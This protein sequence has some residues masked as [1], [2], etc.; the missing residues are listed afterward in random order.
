[1]SD[2]GSADFGPLISRNSSDEAIARALNLFVGRG[3]RY[4]VK[5]FSAATGIPERMIECAK[6]DIE[7]SDHRSLAPHLIA[8]AAKFLG[9]AFINVWL[10]QCGLA[11]CASAEPNHDDIARAS[12]DY[13]AAY[14]AARHPD[15]PGGI[16]IIASEKRQLNEKHQDLRA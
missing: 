6:Q 1:M 7:N 5:D 11:A 2:R 4:S 8:S 14:S 9:P 13:A 3:R 10:D 15:G 12:L 16:A